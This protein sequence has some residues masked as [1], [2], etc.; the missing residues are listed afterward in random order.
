MAG[1]S[2]S[3]GEREREGDGGSGSKDG[4][5]TTAS[6]AL[7]TTA[8]ESHSTGLDGGQETEVGRV[9]RDGA[10]PTPKGAGASRAP[11][12]K[13]GRRRKS[14]LDQLLERMP[15][16]DAAEISAVSSR[17][18]AAY[19]GEDGDGGAG[20]VGG[21]SSRH[22]DVNIGAMLD[23]IGDSS[24]SGN[25]DE[26]RKQGGEEEVRSVGVPRPGVNSGDN[27]P[28][29]GSPIKRLA[30]LGVSA[31]SGWDDANDEDEDEGTDAEGRGVRLRPRESAAR[32]RARATI[33]VAAGSGG[34]GEGATPRVPVA[35]GSGGEGSSSHRARPRS[36]AHTTSG[37][38]NSAS[39]GTSTRSS[40]PR[41]NSAAARSVNVGGAGA[42]TSPPQSTRSGLGVPRR[43]AT[44][45]LT[46]AGGVAAQGTWGFPGVATSPT[47]HTHVPFPAAPSSPPMRSQSVPPRAPQGAPGGG[48]KRD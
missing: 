17:G 34:D 38:R 9:G 13:L 29:D 6:S 45:G 8:R 26:E 48:G 21:S 15:E 35:G 42:G 2:G 30:D 14:T 39:G 1:A 31:R 20:P 25:E 36:A 41:R 47:R 33:E 44:E 32:L 24:H 16:P 7:D 22:D 37:R 18:G 3:D 11:G 40:R 4:K 19:G 10:P 5:Q 27:P 46:P 12:N 28:G 43:S 23:S